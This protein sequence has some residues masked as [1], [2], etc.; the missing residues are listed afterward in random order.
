MDNRVPIDF[1]DS[2]FE[3]SGVSKD[4]LYSSLIQM[5]KKHLKTKAMKDIWTPENPTQNYCYVVAEFVYWYVAPYD[6]TAWALTVPSYNTLHRFVKWPDGTI[7]D[8]SCEQFYDWSEIDYSKAKRRM[9]LQ[10]GCKGPSK[11]AR[12]LAELM[13]YSEIV[14]KS[15]PKLEI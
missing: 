1:L 9:F 7:V 15:P 4:G 14:D 8:L 11:R 12:L 2:M 6:S 3:F 5:G 13:G 10:T